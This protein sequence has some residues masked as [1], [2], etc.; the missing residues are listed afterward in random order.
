LDYRNPVAVNTKT[1]L[2]SKPTPRIII[3]RILR[4]KIRVPPPAGHGTLKGRRQSRLFSA[5]K[6]SWIGASLYQNPADFNRLRIEIRNHGDG[7]YQRTI[8]AECR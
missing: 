7:V 2:Y 8:A 5:N 1:A 4:L 3:T 6:P